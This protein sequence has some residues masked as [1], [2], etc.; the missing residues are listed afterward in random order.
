MKKIFYLSLSLLV[1]FSCNQ[2]DDTWIKDEFKD[3]DNRIETLKETCKQINNEI[4]TLSRMIDAIN[5]NDFVT[6][7]K[8]ITQN[9]VIIGYEIHFSKSGKIEIYHGKDGRDGTVPQISVKKDTD[10]IWYWTIDGE[11]MTDSNGNK[12]PTTGNDGQA[13][14]DGTDGADGAD[15]ADGITP[16]LKIEDGYWH[17]SYDNGM[18]WIRLDKAVGE[19][20]ED[21]TDG[22]S[23]FNDVTHDDKYVY[24]TLADGSVFTLPKESKL[25]I[26]FDISTN[27]PCQPGETLRIPYTIINTSENADIITICEGN[28]KAEVEKT[29]STKGHIVAMVPKT[30]DNSKILVAVSDSRKTVLKTLTFAEGVFTLSEN[31]SLNDGGG[32]LSM[33]VST[34]YEYKISTSASW[35]TYVSTKAVRNETVT[36]SYDPLPAGTSTRSAKIYFTNLYGEAIKTIEI[37]QGS[38]IKLSTTSLQMFLGDEYTLSASSALGHTEFVWYT[39]DSNIARVDENGKVTALEKG[40]ATITVMSSDYK[41]SATCKVN[42]QSILD[43]VTVK[44]YTNGSISYS[45]G[46]VQKGSELCWLIYNN[47][48]KE[49][50]LT[51]VQLRDARNGHTGIKHTLDRTLDPGD[52]VGWYIPLET[53]Y[54]APCCTY[55]FEYNGK[56]YSIMCESPFK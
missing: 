14:T 47:S 6:D 11:W 39:S 53:A 36:F 31:F 45:N 23:F 42:I 27:I 33:S 25:D 48:S 13:G 17:V 32:T 8:N 12:I 21:G 4:A 10:G 30:I 51:Y 52:N 3:L 34:N 40:S 41:Y 50:Y 44:Y 37:F 49:I 26:T 2:Y 9:G 29:S 56:E 35:I 55:Y 46:Q 20:G 54:Y 16:Q 28:W 1:L 43:L 24:I 38:P 5:Q 19:N 15:G 22:K 7:V 18:T